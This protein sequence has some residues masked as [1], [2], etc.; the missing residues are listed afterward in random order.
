MPPMANSGYSS[1]NYG[2]H[3]TDVG[4]KQRTQAMPSPTIHH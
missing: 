2:N 4:V 1:F 3:A